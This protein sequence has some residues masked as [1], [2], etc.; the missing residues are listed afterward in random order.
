MRERIGYDREIALLQTYLNGRPDAH[1][2][3]WERWLQWM[4]RQYEALSAMGLGC[5]GPAAD[6]AT[7]C[8]GCKG[9]DAWRAAAVEYE[10]QNPAPPCVMGGQAV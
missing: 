3:G 10:A 2:E 9:C 4:H 5:D 6:V 1:D 7:D 8:P